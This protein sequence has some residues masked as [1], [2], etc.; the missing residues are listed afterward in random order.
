[1]RIVV[2]GAG[3]AGCVVAARLSESP[4]LE[5]VLLEVGP[6]YRPGPVAGRP[7]PLAPHHQ[8]VARLGLPRARRR[9]A[10]DGA[11]AARAGGR[12]LLGHQRRHRAARAPGALRRVGRPH[13]R[14]RVGELA[15]VV[16]RHRGRPGLRRGRLARRRRADPDQPLPARRRGSSCRSASARRPSSVGHEWIDDHNAP[17]AVGIGPI[18]LNMLGGERQTPA[19]RYLDPALRAAQP[20]AAHRRARRPRSR[21]RASAPAACGSSAPTGPRRSPPTR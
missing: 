2:C 10:A 13:R 16:P 3:T 11:R 20:G 15:A 9:L 18:P 21:S 14:L 12:R 8:G 6:H 1:M 19:D 4:D 17:G 7:G 5:V